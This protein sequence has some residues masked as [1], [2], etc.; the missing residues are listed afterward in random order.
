[1]VSEQGVCNM[2]I[3]IIIISY[4]CQNYLKEAIESCLIQSVFKNN[5]VE[6]IIGDDG[7]RDGSI[8]IIE[9]YEKKHPDLIFHFV[10]DRNNDN[11]VIPSIR[12]SNVIR[13]ALEMSS[14]EFFQILS[15]D[16]VL[17]DSEKIQKQLN[18][19]ESHNSFFSCFSDYI[20]FW[21]Y[22]KK[23]K[24]YKHSIDF[25]RRVFWVCEYRH[26][27]TFLFRRSI[28]P[29]LP[30]RVIDDIGMIYGALICGKTKYIPMLSFGYRQRDESI[31]HTTDRISSCLINCCLLQDIIDRKKLK[32]SSIAKFSYSILFLIRNRAELSQE[33]Y[34]KYFDFCSEKNELICVIKDFNRQK[35]SVKLR[36]YVY[37][38]IGYLLKL[39]NKILFLFEILLV[40]D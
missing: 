1:M 8:K 34:K 35:Y 22:G 12:V 36:L 23:I 6:I 32:W 18:F 21:D 39:F 14:G 37:V 5:T 16:D 13:R 3:S 19:L 33:K 30:K 10:M 2:K 24:T 27:S 7:S 38:L 28:T 25:S 17:L 11:N 4:N 20:L 26:L 15:G 9:E 29:Y 31:V 40:H